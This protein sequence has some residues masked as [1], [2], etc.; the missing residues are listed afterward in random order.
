M[1]STE[2]KR[3]FQKKKKKKKTFVPIVQSV[4]SETPA[5]SNVHQSELTFGATTF[6]FKY[7]RSSLFRFPLQL[8]HLHLSASTSSIDDVL[9]DAVH[10]NTERMTAGP[11]KHSGIS[12]RLALSLFPLSARPIPPDASF[13]STSSPKIAT[14]SS[15][16]HLIRK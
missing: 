15:F 1:A 4:R 13:C 9:S 5:K 6:E 10:D 8:A 12:L 2:V 11:Q 16:A 7:S 14:A 3:G